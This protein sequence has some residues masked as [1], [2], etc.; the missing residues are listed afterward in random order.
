MSVCRVVCDL[1]VS[2]SAHGTH[3]LLSG[4]SPIVVLML[5]SQQPQED[6]QS[7]IKASVGFVANGVGEG[8]RLLA[9][10]GLM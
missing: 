6:H 7:S 1:A 8:D 5:F 4:H 3:D 10:Y 9:F 2:E